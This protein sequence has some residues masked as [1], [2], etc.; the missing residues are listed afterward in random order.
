MKTEEI[1]AIENFIIEIDNTKD[2]NNNKKE[3]LHQQDG[4]IITKP[5]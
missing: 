3:D 2:I 5:N 1:Q 4:R